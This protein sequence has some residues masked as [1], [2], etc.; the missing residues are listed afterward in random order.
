MKISN[1]IKCSAVKISNCS[2]LTSVQMANFSRSSI[3]RRLL[4]NLRQLL[5]WQS[6]TGRRSYSWYTTNKKKPRN[7]RLNE[8]LNGSIGNR[9]VGES[10][11]LRANDQL[12]GFT[13]ARCGSRSS[14]GHRNLSP[15]GPHITNGLSNVSP[16]SVILS[17]I[18]N[19][20]SLLCASHKISETTHLCIDLVQF[21]SQFA[22]CHFAE[23]AKLRQP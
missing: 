3:P 12:S 8:A 9:P 18:I 1:H 15:W 13:E 14:T 19:H 16:A 5:K 4:G 7:K 20:A 6:S 11:D 22:S 17:S 23:K 2:F 21:C 10:L